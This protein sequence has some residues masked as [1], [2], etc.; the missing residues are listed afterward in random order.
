MTQRQIVASSL[1][2][3]LLAVPTVGAEAHRSTRGTGVLVDS[4]S[5]LTVGEQ[6]EYEARSQRTDTDTQT[7]EA[8]DTGIK[9][10]A[11]GVLVAGG[12]ILFIVI[13]ISLGSA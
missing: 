12:F 6:Q 7:Q 2:L 5:A 4:G 11:T 10:V 3:A 13:V 9:D 8:G 1:I